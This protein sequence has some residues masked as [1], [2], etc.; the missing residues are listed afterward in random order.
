MTPI[1][2]YREFSPYYVR[3]HTRPLTRQMHLINPAGASGLI[4]LAGILAQPRL[5]PCARASG[6]GFAWAAHLFVERNRPAAF[7][8]P[9]KRLIGDFHM[10]ALI[11]AGRMNYEVRKHTSSPAQT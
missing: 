6:H 9:F 11:W 5:L 8:Y 7:T 3:E 10:F 4:V 2:S 1:R